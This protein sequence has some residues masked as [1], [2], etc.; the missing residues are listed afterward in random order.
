MYIGAVIGLFY[1]PALLAPKVVSFLGV[2][3]STIFQLFTVVFSIVVGLGIGLTHNFETERHKSC[4]R[5]RYVASLLLTLRGHLSTAEWLKSTR[6]T[7]LGEQSICYPTPQWKELVA[8]ASSVNVSDAD[9]LTRELAAKVERAL[10]CF[11]VGA[12][13][14]ST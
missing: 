7:I 9:V 12:F 11:N 14:A 3:S 13:K 2:A 4:S 10:S 6:S 5:E 8:V 1:L